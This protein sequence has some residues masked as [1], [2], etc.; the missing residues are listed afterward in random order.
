M[1]VLVCMAN[2][3]HSRQSKWCHR[4][5]S[6]LGHE[7]QMDRRYLCQAASVVLAYMPKLCQFRVSKCFRRDS[8]VSEHESRMDHKYTA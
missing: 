2:F 4:G 1:V 5:S 6:V 3:C 8:F 7:Y